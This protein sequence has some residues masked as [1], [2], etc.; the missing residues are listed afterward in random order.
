MRNFC[1][2]EALVQSAKKKKLPPPPNPHEENHSY[3][4]GAVG[5]DSLS[6]KS[7]VTCLVV[8]YSHCFYFY[9]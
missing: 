7:R 3:T 8:V 9:Y 4:P 1:E 5:Q 6:D 2:N